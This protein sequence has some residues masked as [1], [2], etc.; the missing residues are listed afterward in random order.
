MPTF[1]SSISDRR[2]TSFDIDK[3]GGQIDVKG[4]YTFT[5][6]NN[7]FL[8]TGAITVQLSTL[9]VTN[10]GI[11][12][13]SDKEQNIGRISSLS[14][15][16]V[17]F[18]FSYSTSESGLDKLTQ[19]VCENEIVI[20]S[21]E[22]RIIG[23]LSALDISSQGSYVVENA[24]CSLET[25]Q[26]DPEPQPQPQP[27]PE[28]EPEPPED[29]PEQEPDPEPEPPEDD[30][31]IQGPNIVQVGETNRY[32]WA[33]FPQETQ[34]LDWAVLAETADVS[35]EDVTLELADDEAET[36]L[37]DLTV[38]VPGDFLIVTSA[39]AGGEVIEQQDKVV[40]V[41]N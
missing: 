1:N 15:K 29:D 24:N 10:D 9:K 17:T 13:A 30:S 37:L 5:I 8:P 27:Q 35:S 25:E 2:F 7:G 23:T 11:E 38:D 39:I 22:G 40:T 3:S 20:T 19:S 32:E 14:S 4:E 34:R 18:E 12:V 33:D 31:E 6:N 36:L 28:P 41:R 21:T 26:P 16:D